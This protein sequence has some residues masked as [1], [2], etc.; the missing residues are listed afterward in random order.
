M[1]L[2]LSAG[3]SL[4]AGFL[5]LGLAHPVDLNLKG[6]SSWPGHLLQRRK[7]LCVP[8]GKP[9]CLPVREPPPG[10]V[11]AKPTKPEPCAFENVGP[12]GVVP[13]HPPCRPSCRKHS[14]PGVTTTRK[15]R[16]R[17]RK[18]GGGGLMPGDSE[19]AFPSHFRLNITKS[20][21]PFPMR[22]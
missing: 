22:S 16:E 11:T 15:R 14:G 3:V 1:P 6:W 13:P 19:K 4:P 8:S 10:E 17:D 21:T 2:L 5:P 9:A 18:L 7:L 20:K 12:A